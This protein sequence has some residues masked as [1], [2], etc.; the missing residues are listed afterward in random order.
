MAILKNIILTIRALSIKKLVLILSLFFPHPASQVLMTTF[1]FIYYQGILHL[2]PLIEI[3][4]SQLLNFDYKDKWIASP[5]HN[6]L[7][8]KK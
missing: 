4:C 7:L 6:I 2:H 1:F 5:L 3:K 8:G